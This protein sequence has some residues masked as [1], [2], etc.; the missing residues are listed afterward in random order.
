MGFFSDTLGDLFNSYQNEFV[1]ATRETKTDLTIDTGMIVFRLFGNDERKRAA[2]KLQYGDKQIY[3]QTVSSNP[4]EIWGDVR[5]VASG[6]HEGALVINQIS[7]GHEV[8]HALRIIMSN[9]TLTS[10]DMGVLLSP[11]KYLNL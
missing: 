10:E 8:E 11:D 2:Y 9:W 5:E 6:P 3:F 1:A 7:L 4:V